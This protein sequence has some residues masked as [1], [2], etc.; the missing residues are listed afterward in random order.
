MIV[1]DEEPVLDSFSF[2]LEKAADDF[3]LCGKARSG[4]EAISL[5]E[6]VSPDVVFMDIQMPGLNGIDTIEQVRSRHPNTV[7][8]LATAYERFDIARKA[9]PLGV[10]SYLV[11]PISRKKFLEELERVRIHLNRN[12]NIHR[13][14]LQEIELLNKTKN[15]KKDRFL[16]NL[17]WKNPT[18]EDWEEFSG[19]FNLNASGGTV[20][21]IGCKD[22]ISGQQKEEL[23]T[24]ITEKIQYKYSTHSVSLGDKRLLFFPD[25][26]D[27]SAL[28]SALERIAGKVS[29]YKILIGIGSNRNYS[30]LSHSFD[31]AYIPF[32][33][34]E[35][36]AGESSFSEMQ[37]F[38]R[39]LINS[40]PERGENLFRRYWMEQF[41]RCS[42]PVAMGKMVSLFTLLL[43]ELSLF[44]LS[45]GMHKFSPAEE[46]MS[47]KNHEEWSAWAENAM[48]RIYSL[49]DFQNS[50]GYPPPLQHALLYIE[51]HY[52]EPIQLALVAEDAG[53]TAS[54][55]SRLFSEN[56]RTKF[57]DYLNQY[58]LDKA[59]VLLKE[60]KMT[61]KETSYQVGYQDPNYFSRIF[62]KYMGVSPS[63]LEKIG[64]VND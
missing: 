60:K 55:L 52:S 63:D 44:T 48:S 51:E 4:A 5:M 18:A 20:C 38:S 1:D 27:L 13:S 24:D 7:F 35:K 11:K 61:I 31:D 6:Q 45:T 37:E 64:K 49:F 39:N 12:R 3:E 28:K 46:I 23:Y 17:V 10:F 53:V 42:F 8:I 59:M 57:S 33:A 47:L 41:S 56:M 29:S 26:S 16:L 22:P 30:E 19:L 34:A 40:S 36:E 15:D 9:I 25:E 58:R 14:R 2:I 43:T 50:H 62:R 54:Y 32:T 21:L